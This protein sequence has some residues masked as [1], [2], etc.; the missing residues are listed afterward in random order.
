MEQ[1]LSPREANIPTLFAREE[2][3]PLRPFKTK[4]EQLEQRLK[5]ERARG[6]ADKEQEDAGQAD[7]AAPAVEEIQIEEQDYSRELCPSWHWQR[8]RPWKTERYKVREGIYRD[9]L[10]RLGEPGDPQV[11]AF[12]DQEMHMEQISEWWGPGHWHVQDSFKV[13]WHGRYLWMNPPYSRL[14]EVADKIVRDK[15]KAI[16]VVPDWRGD[17]WLETL[18]KFTLKRHCYFMGQMVFEDTGGAPWNV[19]ALLVDTRKGEVNR[20][21]LPEP[22][23]PMK[24]RA[25][26][27][28]YHRRGWN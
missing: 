24:S 25:G 22:D 5:E 20:L 18:M 7:A 11:D 4:K 23:E 8:R 15:L 1:N 10:H 27:R 14:Q 9:I 28:R 21:V 13:S 17:G 26:W 3:P 16:M 2:S 12:A 6:A 19:W